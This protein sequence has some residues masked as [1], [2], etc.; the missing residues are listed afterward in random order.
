MRTKQNG[1]QNK[2]KEKKNKSSMETH[3]EKTRITPQSLNG[4]IIDLET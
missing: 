1:K 2:R 3:R 4:K